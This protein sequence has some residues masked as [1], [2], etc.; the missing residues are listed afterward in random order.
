MPLD[1]GPLAPFEH[2][3]R[4]RLGAG[5]R[6]MRSS[7]PLTIMPGLKMPDRFPVT[8]LRVGADTSSP[9]YLAFQL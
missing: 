5:W 6:C 8:A 1:P 2:R 4:G 9:P 3:V 7:T